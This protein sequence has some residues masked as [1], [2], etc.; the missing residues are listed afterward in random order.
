M[1]QLRE[2][3][4]PSQ[5]WFLPHSST[6][7]CRKICAIEVL[8]RSSESNK[9]NTTQGFRKNPTSLRLERWRNKSLPEQVSVPFWLFGVQVHPSGTNSSSTP[10]KKKLV[11]SPFIVMIPP[12]FVRDCKAWYFYC[13][14]K[15]HCKV[16]FYCQKWQQ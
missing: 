5:T 6:L 1:G 16:Y 9:S 15:R 14:A 2:L 4:A 3:F 12:L 10:D 13:Q 11:C 8:N 7:D